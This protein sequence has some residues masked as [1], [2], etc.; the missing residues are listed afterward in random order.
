VLWL[1]FVWCPGQN[2]T[3]APILSSMD[4]VKV[5]KGC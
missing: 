1:Y 5:T 4:V 3:I 2:K